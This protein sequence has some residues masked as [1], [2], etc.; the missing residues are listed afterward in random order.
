MQLSFFRH[1]PETLLPLRYEAIRK[2]IHLSSIA[3]PLTCFLFSRTTLVFIWGMAFGVAILIELLRM[4]N[5]SFARVFYKCVG[6]LLRNQEYH[7]ITGA[8]YLLGGSALTIALFSRDIAIY[9][10]L[11][12]T[13]SDTVA[14][15]TGFYLGRCRLFQTKT[16]EGS[17][18]FLTSAIV[19]GL[20]LKLSIPVILVGSIVGAILELNFL[21]INDNLLIPIGVATSMEVIQ[22]AF[23]L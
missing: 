16:L 6:K 22:R 9:S 18:G 13:V 10:L 20:L 21:R 4:Q 15:M 17:L 5:P 12:L 2:G 19:L 7:H 3:I 11:I 1:I 23:G 14:A 8:T